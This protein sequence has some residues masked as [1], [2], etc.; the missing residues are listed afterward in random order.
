[1]G[2]SCVMGRLLGWVDGRRSRGG[3]LAC[4]LDF[5]IRE[6]ITGSPIGELYA[7][8]LMFSSFCYTGPRDD[9]GLAG[10]DGDAR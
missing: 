10:V 2:H 9:P 6:E 7:G 5:C 4:L 3:L 1:M 8:V